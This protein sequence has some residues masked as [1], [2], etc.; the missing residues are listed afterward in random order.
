M[1]D[2]MCEVFI[3]LW[4]LNGVDFFALGGGGGV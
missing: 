3:A 1:Y 2:E 4:A